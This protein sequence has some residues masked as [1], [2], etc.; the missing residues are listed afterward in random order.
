MTRDLGDARYGGPFYYA[1]A[2]TDTSVTNSTNL[3]TVASVTLPVGWYYFDAFW[4]SVSSGGGDVRQRF[5]NKS[6]STSFGTVAH[7]A[8]VGTTTHSALT[9]GSGFETNADTYRFY[10]FVNIT[11]EAQVVIEF[12]QNTAST[13]TATIYAGAGMVF[14]RV[15]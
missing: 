6:G 13:N 3:V 9:R 8:H 15:E 7:V 1:I 11:S 4:R 10:G 12:S 14:R 2:K 5:W